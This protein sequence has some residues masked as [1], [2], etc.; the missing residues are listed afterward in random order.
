[1]QSPESSCSD[2]SKMASSDSE[3]YYFLS[4]KSTFATFLYFLR[5]NRGGQKELVSHEKRVV[6]L[7]FRELAA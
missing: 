3:F 6:K 7:I 1:M 4:R 5:L 2:V